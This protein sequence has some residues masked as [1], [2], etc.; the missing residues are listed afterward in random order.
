MHN[1]HHHHLV[2]KER[3]GGGGR[4]S[5]ELMRGLGAMYNL[6]ET[7]CGA[8]WRT[9]RTESVGICSPNCLKQHEAKPHVQ[10]RRPVLFVE[11]ALWLL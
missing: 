3:I 9:H 5:S 6:R 10:F 7:L 8:I 2:Q 4:E 1:L 11:S